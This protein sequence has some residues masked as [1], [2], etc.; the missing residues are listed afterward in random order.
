MLSSISKLLCWAFLSLISPSLLEFI[1]IIYFCLNKLST[2]HL[3]LHSSAN[4]L[5]H[6]SLLSVSIFWKTNPTTSQL[7]I[8]SQIPSDPITIK[9]SSLSNSFSKTS[10]SHET[11]TSCATIS[12]ILLATANP[13]TSSFFLKTLGAPGI[14][15]LTSP[16][17]SWILFF[18]SSLI[19]FWSMLIS[20]H[21]FS[22][23]FLSSPPFLCPRTQRESPTFIE[24]ILLSTIKTHMAHVPLNS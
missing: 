18:S 19:G 23:D 7:L 10:G 21:I 11:P 3:F 4:N 1:S 14:F 2:S 6:I 17:L 13:G 16:P 20:R 8:E 24:N 12:P 22:P 15:S 9:W 5:E